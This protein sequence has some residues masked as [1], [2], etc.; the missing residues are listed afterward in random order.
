MLEE[1]DALDELELEE[2][3]VEELDCIDELEELDELLDELITGIMISAGEPEEPEFNPPEDD[4]VLLEDDV[5]LG[6][7]ELAALDEDEL[8]AVAPE[9]LDEDVL[10]ELA[11][12]TMAPLELCSGG[13]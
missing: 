12:A 5:I 8:I 4:E 11:E 2:E 13:V 10:V 7:P 3:E 1:L 6:E 9:V